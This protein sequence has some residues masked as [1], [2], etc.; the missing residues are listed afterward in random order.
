[1]EGG[2]IAS[3]T[4]ISSGSLAFLFAGGT[5]I[6]GGN[7]TEASGA[8]LLGGLTI[9]GGT[10]GNVSHPGPHHGSLNQAYS[11]RLALAQRFWQHPLRDDL[12]EFHCHSK[13]VEEGGEHSNDLYGRPGLLNEANRPYDI[14]L[15]Q[16]L[17][18]VQNWLAALQIASACRTVHPL[19]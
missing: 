8:S 19:F 12:R 1:M 3:G 5:V 2:A 16:H 14:C 7:I 17:G 11:A 18:G 10:R 15:L 6:S 13:P 9:S 4:V